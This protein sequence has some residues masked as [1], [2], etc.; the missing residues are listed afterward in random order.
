MQSSVVAGHGTRE[1]FLPFLESTGPVSSTRWVPPFGVSLPGDAVYFAFGGVGKDPGTYAEYVAVE[2][3]FVAPKPKSLSFAEAAAAPSSLITAWDALIHLGKLQ[4]GETVLIQAGAGGVGHLAVQLASLRGAHV[5]TTV[6]TAEKAEFARSLGAEKVILYTEK[7]FVEECCAWTGG[8]GV[9]LAIDLVG[10][11][12]FFQTFDAIRHYGRMVT[13]LGPDAKS[14]NWQSARM[15][16]LTVSFYLMFSPMYFDLIEHQKRQTEVLSQAVSL[17][18][19]RQLFVRVAR[20]FPLR[21]AASAHSA[22]ERGDSMGKLV[23]TFD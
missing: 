6:N 7:S 3:R 10:G 8:K 13:M 20:T 15:R 2:E 23:L 14:A 12:T 22:I 17:F 4:E 16:G 1:S 18:E 5:C 11:P 9:D 19:S 21:E